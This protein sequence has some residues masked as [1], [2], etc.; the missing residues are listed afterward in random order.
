MQGLWQHLVL[1][2]R[3]DLF[4]AF[5]VTNSSVYAEI[6]LVYKCCYFVF[7]LLWVVTGF[8]KLVFNIGVFCLVIYLVF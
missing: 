3:T 1:K 6:T 8:I 7:A 4:Y 2:L 5:S